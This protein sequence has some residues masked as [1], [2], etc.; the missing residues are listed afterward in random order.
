MTLPATTIYPI[1]M[2]G[3]IGFDKRSER[4]YVNWYHAG[5]CY[6]LYRYKGQM[7]RDGKM[8]KELA[9]KLLSAMQ[10]AIENGTFRIEQFTETEYDIIPYLGTWLEAIKHTLTPGTYKDYKNSIKN[11]LVPFFQVKAL[12][13]HEIQYDTLIELLGSIDREGKGKLNVMYCLHACLLYAWRSRRIPA[14]P[15][16]PERKHYQIVRPA[17]E[18]LPSER[19]E[20]VIEAIPPEHQPIFWFLK[21]HLRRPG[22]A[23]A[24]RK[25]DFDGVTFTITR[26]VSDGQMVDRTKTGEVHIVPAVSSFL[27]YIDVEEQ[28]QKHYGI[29]SPYFFVHPHGKQEGKHYTHKTLSTLWQT[30]CKTTGENIDLYHGTKHSTASQLIN[31]EGYS[32]YDLQMA[33]DW[34]RLDSVKP[35]GK[36]EV[37]ARKAILERK[38]ISLKSQRDLAGIS[39]QN[40]K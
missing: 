4:Y 15:P 30:A 14:I 23:M 36:I 18:W 29:I 27:T 12:Q 28:K 17:I 9:D 40:N 6:K 7:M 24:L 5:K 38:V 21:Y 3:S 31:E 26:G 8:G 10:N 2:K 16:F 25:E 22:E 37:S 19:Q 33:G 34:A 11:H 13:L 35:Y 32:I 20:A 39:K 1:C